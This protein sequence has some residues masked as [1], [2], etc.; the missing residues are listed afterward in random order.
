MADINVD[1]VNLREAAARHSE[2]SEYLRTVPA[3]H[4]AIQDS[5]DSLGPIFADL[6]E[7]G[8]ELLEQRRQCYQQQADDHAE[9]AAGLT[10]AAGRWEEHEEERAGAFRSVLDEMP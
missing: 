9:M 8:R 1:I 6:R 2:T 4:Q 3:T 7:A 10:E 5:L